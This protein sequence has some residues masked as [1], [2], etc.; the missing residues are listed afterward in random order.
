MHPPP[1][2]RATILSNYLLLTVVTSAVA[3]WRNLVSFE[4]FGSS[5]RIKNKPKNSKY[6]P[7]TC[8]ATATVKKIEGTIIKAIG[9]KKNSTARMSQS[10]C[11]LTPHALSTANHGSKSRWICITDGEVVY[12]RSDCINHGPGT[13]SLARIRIGKYV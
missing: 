2:T 6:G 12:L 13:C 7:Y 8:S 1:W 10:P 5:L 9:E 11:G 4:S 3:T